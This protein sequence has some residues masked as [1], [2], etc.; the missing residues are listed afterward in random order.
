MEC[1]IALHALFVH[2]SSSAKPN[3]YK[4]THS[5]FSLLHSLLSSTQL[6]SLYR[7]TCHSL[8]ARLI[9]SLYHLP[10][11]ARLQ[12]EIQQHGLAVYMKRGRKKQGHGTVA[13]IVFCILKPKLMKKTG[14]RNSEAKV[15]SKKKSTK[16]RVQGQG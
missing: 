6:L 11:Y 2:P 1:I 5:Y 10:R 12:S 3:I 16:E 4:T 7:D 15:E 8:S 14:V 13:V 9:R